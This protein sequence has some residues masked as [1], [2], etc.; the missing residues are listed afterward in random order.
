MTGDVGL[1]LEKQG[2]GFCGRSCETWGRQ[3]QETKGGGQKGYKRNPM[4]LVLLYG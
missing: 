1:M 4:M 2:C 3:V